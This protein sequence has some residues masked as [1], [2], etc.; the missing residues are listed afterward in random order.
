MM[1]YLTFYKNVIYLCMVPIS[2]YR[3]FGPDKEKFAWRFLIY[4]KALREN[5]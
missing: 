1:N 5:I 2:A 3:S 4:V